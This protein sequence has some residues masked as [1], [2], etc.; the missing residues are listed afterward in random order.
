M[1]YPSPEEK[2][3]Q[4]E[5]RR[6]ADEAKRRHEE[7]ERQRKQRDDALLL[8]MQINMMNTIINS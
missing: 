3:K 6:K 4:A 5:E 1:N 7:D 2:A 8:Q